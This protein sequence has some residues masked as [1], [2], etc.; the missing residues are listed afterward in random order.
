[1]KQKQVDMKQKIGGYEAKISIYE[2]NQVDMKQT[3]WI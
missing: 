1:M 2:A 3:R